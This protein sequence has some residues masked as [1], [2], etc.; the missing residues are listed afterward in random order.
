MSFKSPLEII[1]S[2]KTKNVVVQL[3][4]GFSIRGLLEDEGHNIIILIYI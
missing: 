2:M 3:K 4:N 1:F